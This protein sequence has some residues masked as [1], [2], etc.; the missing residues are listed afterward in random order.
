MNPNGFHGLHKHR[1]GV[2]SHMR[3]RQRGRFFYS[4]RE[5]TP[6]PLFLKL[7]KKCEIV[8]CLI[9]IGHG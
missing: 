9:S 5:I 2:E 1:C 6:Q 7:V 3:R 8:S 4:F